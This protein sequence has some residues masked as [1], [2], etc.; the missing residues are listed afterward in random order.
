MTNKHIILD[1][2]FEYI[3]K[4]SSIYNL[5]IKEFDE[6]NYSLVEFMTRAIY[7][8][9]TPYPNALKLACKLNDIG[10]PYLAY[11]FL[12]KESKLSKNKFQRQYLKVRSASF[13]LSTG[14]YKKAE[15]ILIGISNE[16]GDS[17]LDTGLSCYISGILAFINLVFYE[18]FMKAEKY[19]NRIKKIYKYAPEKNPQ[20]FDSICRSDI[21][22]LYYHTLCDIY[23]KIAKNSKYAIKRAYLAKLENLMNYK[24]LDVEYFKLMYEL[25]YCE[26]QVLRGDLNGALITIKSLENKIKNTHYERWMNSSIFSVYAS[27][28]SEMNDTKR[29]YKYFK[30][31][32]MASKIYGNTIDE[33]IMINDSFNIVFKDFKNKNVSEIIKYEEPLI[34]QLIQFLRLKDWYTS[35]DHSKNVRN[36]TINIAKYLMKKKQIHIS[37]HDLYVLKF[38]AYLHDI[39]K[40]YITWF[41]LNKTAPL[42]NEEFSLIKNHTVFGKQILQ[43]LNMDKLG[44]FAIGHHER[45]DG[46]GYPKGEKNHPLLVNIVALADTFD[47]GTST[48]RKYRKVRKESEMINEI[49]KLSGKAF[50]PK[51]VNAIIKLSNA[52]INLKSYKGD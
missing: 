10:D 48:S 45:I 8:R 19:L 51:I 18:N 17:D 5:S 52:G 46:S 11:K 36:I 24:K 6:Y 16:L 31:S 7:D 34:D 50:Y 20:G 21:Y 13:L 9:T 44:D 27:I 35:D 25:N 49:K 33:Y 12:D 39:G 28:Y 40:L 22:T 30:R 3:N 32:I 2:Y 42:T 26:L 23:I 4:I 38:G 43:K 37:E 41:E 15:I 14:I 1:N 29:T 47:A